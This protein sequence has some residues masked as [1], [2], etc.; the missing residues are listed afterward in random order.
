MPS[1]ASSERVQSPVERAVEVA[2]SAWGS[3]I[4]GRADGVKRVESHPVRVPRG[5]ASPWGRW[6]SPWPFRGERTCWTVA[7]GRGDDL[8]R[9]R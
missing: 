1:I 8:S 5:G 4:A 7:G 6:A 9:G 2:T 3:P